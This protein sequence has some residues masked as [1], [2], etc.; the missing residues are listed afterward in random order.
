MRNV[1]PWHPDGL[2]DSPPTSLFIVI[3]Y[4]KLEL[5]LN[6]WARSSWLKARPEL[7]S[8]RLAPITTR[9]VRD[10]LGVGPYRGYLHILLRLYSVKVVANVHGW[11]AVCSII[12]STS[13]HAAAEYKRSIVVEWIRGNGIDGQARTNFQPY[14]LKL[15]RYHKLRASR[16][17]RSVG[18]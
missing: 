15:M 6:S 17:P 12:Q 16:I 14:V 7:D 11:T 5:R 8:S 18:C 2:K 3:W 10:S 9:D 1:P 13:A 4:Q